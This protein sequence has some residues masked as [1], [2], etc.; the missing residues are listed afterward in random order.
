M[1]RPRVIVT[2]ILGTQ[3]QVSVERVKAATRVTDK[4]E[5]PLIEGYITS[6]REMIEHL[7]GR[8]IRQKTMTASFDCIGATFPWWDGVVECAIS[9]MGIPAFELPYAPLVSVQQVRMYDV[10]DTAQIA[11]ATI[12]RVDISSQDSP[13]RVILKNGY[14]WPVVGRDLNGI[15]IDY[16]VGYAT[17]LTPSPL[18][19][20]IQMLASHFYT[21]RG[22]CG[23]PEKCVTD[24]GCGG[25][26]NT[27]RIERVTA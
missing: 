14:A 20:A 12:Y 4:S 7:T 10:N 22:D 6:A 1:R 24:A 3:E 11:S 8:A 17:G 2:A 25:L 9:A 23:T 15:E 18:L 19:L 27:Y 26:I 13:G 16:T 21:N 5:E